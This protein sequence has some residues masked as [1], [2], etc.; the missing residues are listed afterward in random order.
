[1]PEP[2]LRSSLV[3]W[4]R[5]FARRR[6]RLVLGTLLLA[7]TH[8][9]AVGL[10]ALSGWF[11]TASALTGLALAAG[12]AV[13][14]DVYVPGGGIRFFALS[15]TVSRYGERFYNHDTVLRFLADLRSRLFAVL[16][17]LD[18]RSLARQ[19]ASDWLNR[20]TA[21][22]DT[23]DSL[24]LRLLAPPLVALLAVLLVAALLSLWLPWV[25]IVVA[26][27]L[28]FA[29]GWL[30]LGQAWLGMSA[31][32]RQ[33]AHLQRLRGQLVEH[34]QGQAELE[35][36]ASQGWHRRHI[37]EQE[38]RLQHDQRFLARWAGFGVALVNLTVGLAMLA[39]LWLAALAWQQEAIGGAVMVMMPLAV[40]ACGEALALLP[41][42]FTHLGATR[43]AA[44]RLNALVRAG[45]AVS[46]SGSEPLPAGPLSLCLHNVSLSY[47]DALEPALS[48][49]D[50]SL[51]SGRRLALSGASGAGKSSVAAL[52]A[53]RLPPSEGEIV[54]GGVPLAHVDERALRERVA[55]LGQRVDLFQG[56]LAANLRLA[57]PRASEAEL[58]QALA[59]VALDDWA[60][61][62]P[63]G[64]ETPV[65][66]GGRALSGGQ[67]RRVALAR[68]WLRDPG[69][70]ILDEPFAGLDA[71]TVARIKP[72]LDAWLAGRSAIY[73]VHQLDGGDFDPPGITHE[74]RLEQGKLTDCANHGHPSG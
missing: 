37:E 26:T 19:R 47:P 64:L 15:R 25:G 10:L 35:A 74:A 17:R 68:L 29:W 31:S 46:T 45:E 32:R 33:V 65:G 13:S 69:L 3:P 62:L 63:S 52:V 50:L 40:L 38:A 7:I 34:L 22:I 4:L 59:W 42:A 49:I 2:S 60:R 61:D 6:R 16:A 30:T 66:E 70:V 18:E 44:D 39:A 20:L 23:L 72:R 28:L 12:L 24:F 56:S 57:A 53:R 1:M 54:L 67:A 41:M 71:D 73:L 8:A 27:V 11:I 36:Y 48:G 43:G 58:W 9:S 55:L 51:A 5:L 21:D 14:L